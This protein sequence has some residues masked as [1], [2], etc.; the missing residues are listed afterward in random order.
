MIFG[1]QA[2]TINDHSRAP[3]LSA[4]VTVGWLVVVLALCRAPCLQ[5][6]RAMQS[7]NNQPNQ[8]THSTW[9]AELILCCSAVRRLF[10]SW[11]PRCDPKD[12]ETDGTAAANSDLI[13]TCKNL[14]S[15]S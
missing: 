6:L 2:S 7:I 13:S 15:S 14:N 1:A 5:M 10:A 3:E 11:I 9:N 12:G 8:L 4:P